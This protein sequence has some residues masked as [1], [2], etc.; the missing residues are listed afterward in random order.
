MTPV[1][2]GFSPQERTERNAT[3]NVTRNDFALNAVL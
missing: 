3:R 1:L 2:F